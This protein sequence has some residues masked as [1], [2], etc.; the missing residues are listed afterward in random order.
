MSK[1][2]Q[3]LCKQFKL[4]SNIESDIH[5]FLVT[6]QA[7]SSTLPLTLNPSVDLLRMDGTRAKFAMLI[8]R[9]NEQLFSHLGITDTTSP[10]DLLTIG[11]NA[12]HSSFGGYVYHYT[13]LENAASIL[14]D[15]AL[16][17]RNNLSPNDFRDSSAKHVTQTTRNEVK[18]YARFYFRPLTPMQ[19]CNEN[20]GLSN[21]S[22]KCGNQPICPVPIFF[23]IKLDALLAIENI[24]WKVSLG[25]LANPQTEFDNTM[26]TVRKFD[27]RGVYDNIRT[28]RGMY[29]SHQEFLIKSQLN[30][31]ELKPEHI[32]IIC[33]DENARC[34]LQ[35]MISH[36]YSSII[37]TSYYYGLNSRVIISPP[38]TENE[39]IVFI[40]GINP[41]RVDGQ[42]ILQLSGDDTNRT[43]HGNLKAS[44][45]RGTISTVYSNQQLSFM[46]DLNH[47]RYAVYYEHENQMWLI[48]T[49][50]DGAHFIQPV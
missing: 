22:N 25:N 31:D 7:T 33:P 44:F 32:E 47:V 50:S 23:R 1:L 2:P 29:S 49:N 13:H 21:L 43:I 37:G 35:H 38:N 20:L 11:L 46:A 14:R 42:L 12:Q 40:N 3:I 28:E 48:H 8:D 16:K 5:Q 4:P 15:H 6:E 27:F 41:S 9:D 39:I 24:Q 19:Y 26:N 17:C 34:S 10:A 45:Q 30:F 36:S 18:D